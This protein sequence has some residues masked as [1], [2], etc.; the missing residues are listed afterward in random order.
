MLFCSIDLKDVQIIEIVKIH[1]KNLM[2]I[3]YF[4]YNKILVSEVKD[5]A[6]IAAID[7]ES[8]E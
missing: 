4:E 8:M 2:Q 6:L 1:W 7:L 3:I 5:K